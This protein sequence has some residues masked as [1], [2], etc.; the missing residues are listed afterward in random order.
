MGNKSPNSSPIKGESQIENSQQSFDSQNKYS[1]NNKECEVHSFEELPDDSSN[2][3]NSNKYFGK[4][5]KPIENIDPQISSESKTTNSNKIT[6]AWHTEPIYVKSQ[7]K[8]GG[9]LLYIIIIK[10][11]NYIYICLY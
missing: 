4:S 1:N 6:A 2:A 9:I 11:L 8:Q 3:S 5:I 10:L 7:A